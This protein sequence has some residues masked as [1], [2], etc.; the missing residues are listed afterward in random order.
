MGVRRNKELMRT[1]KLERGLP[2]LARRNAKHPMMWVSP[3]RFQKAK[4]EYLELEALSLWVWA[5][6]D[7]EGRLP[8]ST[9]QAIRKRCPGF[10]EQ[11][12]PPQ[13]AGCKESEPVSLRLLGWI[14]N[15]IFSDAKRGGWLDALLSYTVGSPRSQ[16]TWAYWEHCQREWKKKRPRSY[17]SFEA[18]SRAAEKWKVPG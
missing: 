3:V 18:W 4:Q 13:K 10:L 14:H 8:Q 1:T 12:K 16:R 11:G 5:I 9:L 17:P 15:H 2:E 6:I 7:M